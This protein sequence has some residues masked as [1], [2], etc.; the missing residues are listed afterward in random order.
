M[1]KSIFF[2][3]RLGGVTEYYDVVLSL[4]ITSSMYPLKEYDN[5]ILNV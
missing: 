1:F 2:K 3:S 4:Q 5:M